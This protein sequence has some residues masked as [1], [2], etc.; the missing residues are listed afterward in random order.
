MPIFRRAGGRT[1]S[2][3]LTLGA[4]LTIAGNATQTITVSE[5]PNP[6]N[7]Y[8]ERRNFFLLKKASGDLRVGRHLVG[9]NLQL[10]RPSP[11]PYKEVIA[12]ALGRYF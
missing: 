3:G 10:H 6:I 1:G 9:T 11:A 2:W 7:I 5:E 12:V 4:G 8:R